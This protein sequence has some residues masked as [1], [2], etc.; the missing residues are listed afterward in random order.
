MPGLESSGIPLQEELLQHYSNI[1]GR[2]H[3]DPYWAYYKA[4]YYW[5]G[6]IISQGIDARNVVG[7]ASSTLASKYAALT[8]LLEAAAEMHIEELKQTI[9]NQRPVDPVLIGTVKL[10]D[11]YCHKAGPESNFNESCYFNFFDHKQKL[12]GFIR[13]GNRVNEHY[14]ERTVCIFLNDGTVLFSFKRPEISSNNGWFC[15]GTNIQTVRPMA[16]LRTEFH[17]GV[18][19]LLE[20]KA[21]LDPKRALTTAKKAKANVVVLHEGCGP[22][23]GRAPDNEAKPKTGG[24]QDNFA[25]NHYEQH[26]RVSGKLSYSHDAKKEVNIDFS[27]FGLRDHRYVRSESSV[28]FA[29]IRAV[30]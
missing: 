13:V 1:V 7:Q 19:H 24:D 3:P 22:V 17:G 2:P 28:H 5:R 20:P 25:K 4:F 12:G 14:A 11:D 16:T 10:M 18:A 29:V 8:P 21:L 30:A 23:F 9:G 27:G 15:A 26:M 6:A